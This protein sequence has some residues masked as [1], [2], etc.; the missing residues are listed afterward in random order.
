MMMWGMHPPPWRFS[1][2]LPIFKTVV[3]PNERSNLATLAHVYAPWYGHVQHDGL[4]D[5]TALKYV[6]MSAIPNWQMACYVFSSS[7]EYF[8]TSVGLNTFKV[9]SPLPFPSSFR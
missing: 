5:A 2:S 8:I 9:R 6:V 3:R 4:S 1:D 7:C